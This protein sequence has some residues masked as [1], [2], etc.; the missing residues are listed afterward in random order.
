MSERHKAYWKRNVRFL[1]ILLS[2]WFI[3]S[4]ILGI[5][6]SDELD[7]YSFLG[8]KLG[9]WIAQQGSIIVYIVL[10]FIYVK[11]MERLDKEFD[12]SDEPQDIS[13]H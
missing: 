13:D 10:I 8:F 2:V 4:F 11:G 9:F 3:V 5:A 1:I 12:I 7:N 6:L